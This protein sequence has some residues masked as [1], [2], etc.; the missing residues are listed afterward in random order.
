MSTLTTSFWVYLVFAF[1]SSTNTPLSTNHVEPNPNVESISISCPE[2]I[3]L[4]CNADP[5]SF[6]PPDFSQ[7]EVVST[8]P[9]QHLKHIG[10]EF[11][12]Q[13]GC[14]IRYARIFEA[15]DECGNYARCVSF[16][17]FC[18]DEE[19]PVVEH[20]QLVLEL[21][22]NADKF[23]DITPELVGATDN[24]GEVK[25][26]IL[27][28]NENVNGCKHVKTIRYAAVDKCGNRTIC[29]VRF[30]WYVDNEPPQVEDCERLVDLG[31]NPKKI[32]EPNPKRL[33]PS[34]DCG[35]VTYEL[36]STVLLVDGCNY[37]QIYTYIFR[38]RCENELKCTETFI[39]VSDTLAPEVLNCNDTIDL[40]C[41]PEEIP[42]FDP[43]L[44]EAKDN[45]EGPVEIIL[46]NS[47]DRGNDCRKR[48]I[49]RFAVLDACN[50]RTVCRLIY[51]W[52][53]DSEPPVVEDCN[54]E[55][56][57][58]CNP[59]RIPEPNPKRLRPEDNCGR[60]LSEYFPGDIVVEGCTYSLTYTY[61]FKDL[62]DNAI[63]CYETFVWTVDEDPPIILNCQDGSIRRD[64]G[65]IADTSEIPPAFPA[66]LIIEDNCSPVDVILVNES[67]QFEECCGRFVRRY[68][69]IDSCG[70]RAH[71]RVIYTFCIDNEEPKM[72]CPEPEDL[73]CI[74][75][76]TEV[77]LPDPNRIQTT[78]FCGDVEVEFEE[79]FLEGD[80]CEYK[81]IYIYKATDICG[82]MS[83]CEEIFI[84]SMD[85]VPPQVECPEEFDFG[86]VDEDFS[87]PEPDTSR[88][89]YKDNCGIVEVKIPPVDIVVIN[90][91][92]H[93]TWVYI[94][95]D[96]CGNETVCFETFTWTID[97]SPPEMICP[98][99]EDL[100]CITSLAE[101]PLPDP[102]R[103]Q[104][105]DFCG[106]VEVEF[107]ERFLEGDP[108][109]YKMIYIYKAT[110]ICGNM[111]RC[112]EV[113]IFSMDTVP[114]QVECPE[115]FDFGCVDE[116]F[117][118]PEPDTS[119][120]KYEDNCGIAEVKIPPVDIV[121][122]NCTYHLTWVYIFIDFCGNETVCFETFTWTIDE[123]SPAMICP[124]PEDLGCI[125]SLAE[126]PLPDPD[127]IEVSDFC[128]DVEVEFEE[129]L[130][131]GDPCEYQLIYIYKATDI[132]GNMSRCEEIFIFSMDTIPPRVKCENIDLGCN[133][134]HI[135][136]ISLEDLEWSDN[137]GGVEIQNPISAISFEGCEYLI[138]QAFDL[139]DK[140][141]NITHCY[142]EITYRVDTTAPKVICEDLDLGCNP[143][144]I[145]QISL[146][147]I[148]W[149]DDCGTVEIQN[150][151]SAISFEGCDY[152]ISQ[153]FDLVDKC[154]N[155]TH[156]Y[157]E[158][159]YRVD[160]TAPKVICEDLDLG[161]NP[162]YIPQISLDDI[163]WS[164]DCGGV[165]IQNP[166]S[167]I[168]FEG[169]D[170]LISQ[171]FDLVDS[172]GNST[173]CYRE[174][175][176][177]ID[178]IAPDVHCVDLDLG[179]N[180]DSIPAIGDIPMSD[181]C[182]GEVIIVNAAS[183]IRLEGCTTYITQSLTA[184]DSCGNQTYCEREIKFVTDT[185]GPVILECP[186]SI[187]LGC[188]PDEIPGFD[189]TRVK[190]EDDCGIADTLLAIVDYIPN[191]CEYQ[192]GHLYI[193][194]DS[195][196][197]RS[198]C[199]EIFAWTI[200]DGPPVF[201][202]DY[203]SFLESNPDFGCTSRGEENLKVF[204]DSIV[205][206]ISDNCGDFSV[207]IDISVIQSEDCREIRHVIIKATDACG[208]ST[209][210][211]GDVSWIHVDPDIPEYEFPTDTVVFDCEAP[212]PPIFDNENCGPCKMNLVLT[213]DGGC[214]NEICV[215]FRLW[216]KEC[217]GKEPESQFQ[218]I[219]IH[220]AESVLKRSQ[221]LNPNISR[222]TDHI[223]RLNNPNQKDPDIRDML[224]ENGNLRLFPNPTAGTINVDLSGLKSLRDFELR[225]F[226]DQGKQY[227]KRE[228]Q[229]I[230]SIQELI[231]LDN[232]KS[233]PY[234]LIISDGS[235]IW[236]QRFI[237]ID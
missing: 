194:I 37:S 133:P 121:V 77:P 82:N 60:V 114:P 64:L 188:N 24:C 110:D 62:C 26:Q 34:D 23:P 220:C 228:Y 130:L 158:I 214:Q 72:V 174:I 8:C 11:Y 28:E 112:E 163:E 51:Q 129:R 144:Y 231:A 162:E 151:I 73:G 146:D 138:S 105:T 135:P 166:I 176:Y 102:N 93:L 232:F 134:E 224:S 115:E 42:E 205:N 41:N 160:T 113:F 204:I 5:E 223:I 155:I 236:Y 203:C 191:G 233:G 52:I 103:T 75:S 88:I 79:R 13:E 80:P 33:K 237:K 116:D 209:V 171:A 142:R 47:I 170:Y 157:R 192:V 213:I 182:G 19:P 99:P 225:I 38:D 210:C 76:L 152:L 22:C 53:E 96:F 12:E 39:W 70:N 63:T 193:F 18:V 69:V 159:T 123:S 104:A 85:T 149:S 165:E 29:R 124:E 95:I 31:C 40:G 179:C 206:T 137:C 56:D 92:Y 10:D 226:D 172:C 2:T 208:Q 71:C 145:P 120:I 156:C 65:C 221:E 136:Q 17:T 178:T 4:P 100:G 180:P 168:S 14:T 150:A 196:G 164:D 9:I 234:T 66:P 175:T 20:C 184:E 125:T 30:V 35:P 57:L 153:A 230:N 91:T 118:P 169:C 187:H 1:V 200:D 167:A 32:P 202:G 139:V 181:N 190:V 189:V 140:C 177:R 218:R 195:C 89:K 84:F 106:D 98:E 212:D 3:E 46:L 235:K 141:G 81:M 207:D 147:D 111:S 67:L 43:T 58:G 21:G 44:I 6:P 15:L 186:D 143:E 161:C 7:V 131:K 197:N 55:V 222:D 117:S 201:N 154:G 132:C 126:V 86:C 45:C 97:E 83:R 25:I 68:R 216:V 90:C 74:T 50:N 87:P 199:L 107:E 36:L 173:H 16:L 127:R 219:D 227:L 215:L 217:C 48:R 49:Y 122:I 59:R 108:C 128:G 78:D 198:S 119:R 148:E 27:S 109:E 183:S 211:E 185:S 61:I 94:F 229:Q 54:R 101:V